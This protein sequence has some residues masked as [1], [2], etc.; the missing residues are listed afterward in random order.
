MVILLTSFH[1]ALIVA[2][3]WGIW[4]KQTSLKKFFWPALSVKLIA[5]ICLGLLYTYYYSVADTFDYFRDA[6]KLASLA[7]KDFSSY[8]DLLFFNTHLESLQL[9]FDQ[10][11]AV[12]LTK[13][14]SVFSILTN[15]NY[16]IIGAYLSLISFWGAWYLVQA[17]NR[18]I[19]SVGFAA[20]VAF[21]FLPSAV[22]W[23]SGLLKESLALAGLFYLSAIFLRIWFSEK[24]SVPEWLL[25]A[26]SL[27]VLWQLKYYYAAVFL[28]VI[29]TSVLYKFLIRK[30]F[31]SSIPEVA[32]W[33]GILILPLVLISFLHPNFYPHRLLDVILTN[34]AAYREFSAPEDL[35]HFHNLRPTPLSLLKNAPWALFSG[36]FRPLVWETSAVIQIPPG[37]ENTFVLLLFLAASVR[38]KKYFTS[39][40]RV[41]ILTLTVYV[42]MLCIFITFSAPNF[43]TLSRYRSGYFSFF[44]FIIL[45]SN[46]LV[47]YLERSFPRLVSH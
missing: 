39:P 19:P 11:R 8:L 40:H 1:I 33:L 17:I 4:K 44:V 43:G 38:F 12:F 45:C 9:V 25:A 15:N 46:P 24:P 42:V 34:H 5:G 16:W 32:V 7:M 2:L 18:Y 29:C 35:V 22:F 26:V 13:I 47:Q 37:I 30:R 10:P 21:L 20:V 3:A 23:S 14:T 41:L 6:S 28:P 27:L 36:L 31:Q